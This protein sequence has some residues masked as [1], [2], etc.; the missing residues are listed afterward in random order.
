MEQGGPGDDNQYDKVR[1]TKP[2]PRS[3]IDINSGNSRGPTLLKILTS[4]LRETFGHFRDSAASELITHN[5]RDIKVEI[6]NADLRGHKSM[7]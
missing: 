5:A 4:S 3:V 2:W 7:E 6:V 1:G